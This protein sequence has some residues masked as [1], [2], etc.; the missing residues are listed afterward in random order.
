MHYILLISEFIIQ[1]NIKTTFKHFA[2]SLTNTNIFQQYISKHTDSLATIFMLH[3]MEIGIP[4][5]GGHSPEFLR[6]ALTYLK[7]NGYHF[8]SV[9]EL[10][11]RAYTG[12]T[13]IQKAVA[14]TMDDGYLD[15]AKI[16]LPIF[17]EFNCPIT[18]FLITGFID[19]EVLPWDTVVKYCFY[20]TKKTSL[21]LNL[22]TKDIVY[23]LS[24]VNNR[25]SS[26]RN[27]REKC[28]TLNESELRN[29]IS[30]LSIN[31]NVDIHKNTIEYSI[32]LSWEDARIAESSNEIRFGIHTVSH[33]I[34]SNISEQ[35]SKEEINNSW[36]KISTELKNPVNIFAYPIGH[37]NDFLLRDIDILKQDGY[38]GAVTAE[39]GYFNQNEVLSNEYAKFMIR[40][41][42]FPDNIPD[43]MQY[44]TGLELI[45]N[46]LRSNSL[47]SIWR[48]KRYLLNNTFYN[49]YYY[50]GLYREYKNIDWRSISRLIF[51]CKGNICRSPYAEWKSKSL[52]LRAISIGVESDGKSSADEMAMKISAL[53]G[54]DISSHIS[55]RLNDVEFSESDLIVCMEPKHAASI[56]NDR[57]LLNAK[58]QITLLG[59][60]C[61]DRKLLV[62]DPYGQSIDVFF[63][64]FELI[65]NALT[66]IHNMI[67]K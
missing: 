50:L 22:G 66:T 21:T 46:K 52:G 16:A 53:R 54:I 31:S 25:I 61:S 15:Q 49:L 51:V 45:K 60:W 64:C 1:V 43:L 42:S 20:E 29:A 40:R 13:P 12:A 7:D 56:L 65:D 28:K 32:P 17:V 4:K 19:K 37:Y 23:N 14:F 67:K 44:C 48:H 6:S 5:Y 30:I 38:L 2:V 34:L 63:E 36:K 8:V 59:L 9:E 33:P 18:V 27:F 58:C 62:R 11:L 3:R 55:R 47:F 35:R 57:N 24:N 41:F 26:M 39:P 10:L